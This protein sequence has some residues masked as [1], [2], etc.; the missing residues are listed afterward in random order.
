MSEYQLNPKDS[1]LVPAEL[2]ISI[3]QYLGTKSHN[4]VRQGVSGLE[5]ALVDHRLANEVKPSNNL[6][7]A[8]S[9]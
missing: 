9:V 4:E 7:D 3:L 8:A 6:K 5:K 1:V 2:I